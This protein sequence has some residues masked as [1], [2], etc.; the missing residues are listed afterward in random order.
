MTLH[1]RRFCTL[2][3]NVAVLALVA[4][5][6]FLAH[7]F[8]FQELG[9]YA[10]DYFYITPGFNSD[11]QTI[12]NRVLDYF[13]TLPQGRPIGWSLPPILAGLAIPLGG[14]PMAYLAAWGIATLNAFLCYKF[15][16]GI[17]S[18]L[19]ALFGALA[20][21]LFPADTTHP[22]LMHAFGLHTSLTLLL[23]A[24]LVYF[25]RWRPLSYLLILGA[26]LTYE[27]G[28]LPFVGLPLLERQWDRRWAK[29]ALLHLMILG[30]LLLTVLIVRQWVG[31]VR[32]TS[33][34]ANP[35]DVFG[36]T[37][38]SLFLGPVVALL[39]FPMRAFLPWT[40]L[41]W[42]LAAWV[43][44]FF[45][46]FVASFASVAPE[47]DSRFSIQK[48]AA[49]FFGG[50]KPPRFR[51]LARKTELWLG[52]GALVLMALGYGL[53]FTHF[54]PITLEGQYTSVHLGATLGAAL[55]VGW[56][57]ALVLAASARHGLERVA[58][59]LLALFYASLGGFSYI[60]QREY[61]QSWI[62]QR[63]FWSQ[64]VMLAPDIQD[65]TVLLLE[66]KHIK[67]TRY[68]STHNPH[69]DWG[70]LGNL[71]DF[72][73]EWA[74]EPSLAIIPLDGKPHL[75][76][77]PTGVYYYPTDSDTVKILLEPNNVIWLETDEAGNLFRREGILE[78]PDNHFPLK[79]KQ[80]NTQLAHRPLY[81]IMVKP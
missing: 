37:I 67:A 68:V 16:K 69:F 7:F 56:L 63:D 40:A 14:L 79:P 41:F 75:R 13:F 18:S 33:E 3:P 76:S 55:F 50:I 52:F 28:F 47:P 71:Y 29:Q 60:V 48:P 44:M 22:F 62:F 1:L 45:I 10:D 64:V 26:L 21:A 24:S 54:P 23:F 2:H 72:P 39:A 31:E 46:V 58:I 32:V 80:G 66:W 27:S 9:L 81:S 36:K 20:F 61:R 5:V 4:F 74:R 43:G 35:L 17:G 70:M 73:D 15:F 57:A 38:I 11:W 42:G 12:V 49:Q 77:E 65:K 34:L 51:E 6:T 25:S 8:Y 78:L 59:I 30:G 53:S 19:L